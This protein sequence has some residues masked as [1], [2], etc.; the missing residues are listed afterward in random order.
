MSTSAADHARSI[1]IVVTHPLAA[2]AGQFARYFEYSWYTYT[3]SVVISPPN[4]FA[5]VETMYPAV[6]SSGAVSPMTRAIARIEPETMPESAV[7]NTTLVMVRCLVTPS[8]SDASR[9]SFGTILSISSVV[10]TTVGIMS[11]DSATD[12]SNPLSVPGPTRIAN[13]E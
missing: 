8:A 13:I 6:M 1:G 10:F 12:P 5:F 4:R 11:S 3:G 9:R 7:R 2:S